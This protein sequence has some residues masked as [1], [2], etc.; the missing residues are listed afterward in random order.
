MATKTFYGK[1]NEIQDVEQL[2]KE[3]DCKIHPRTENHMK[4][5]LRGLELLKTKEFNKKA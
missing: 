2:L 5:I 1:S 3:I 4:K